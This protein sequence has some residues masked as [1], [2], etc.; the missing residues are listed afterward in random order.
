MIGAKLAHDEITSDLRSGGTGDSYQATDTKLDRSVAIK[1][2][3]KA[4]IFDQH[5]PICAFKRWFRHIFLC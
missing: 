2:L 5:H 3:P 4:L 1:I